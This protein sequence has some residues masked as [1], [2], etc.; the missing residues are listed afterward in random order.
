MMLLHFFLSTITVPL[1]QAGNLRG[2]AWHGSKDVT[3]YE[4][5]TDDALFFRNLWRF[6]KKGMKRVYSVVCKGPCCEPS[7]S[8]LCLQ[9][10]FLFL[11]RQSLANLF[12]LVSN[13]P[14]SHLRFLWREKDRRGG[15]GGQHS[16][17]GGSHWSCRKTVG[18]SGLSVSQSSG[19]RRCRLLSRAPCRP[20]VS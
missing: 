1:P 8:E 4:H 9:I 14:F 10:F 19:S 18:K 12:R 15:E 2:R 11:L 3:A 16:R 13:L 17:S 6:K 20:A 5:Q 7:T